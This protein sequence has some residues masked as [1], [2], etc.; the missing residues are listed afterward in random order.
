MFDDC[1]L[2]SENL[3]FGFFSYAPL[4]ISLMICVCV[5]SFN[6]IEEYDLHEVTDFISP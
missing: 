3:D 2:S 4:Y 1:I 5:N 6:E